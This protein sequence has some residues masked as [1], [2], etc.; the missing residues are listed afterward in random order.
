MRAG[1]YLESS[2]FRSQLQANFWNTAVLQL[3]VLDILKCLRPRK[4]L[5]NSMSKLAGKQW[6]VVMFPHTISAPVNDHFQ[7]EDVSMKVS[8]PKHFITLY[9]TMLQVITDVNF[10]LCITLLNLCKLLYF[11]QSKLSDLIQRKSQW[12]KITYK[13]VL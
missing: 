4:F 10:F 9:S 13:K 8:G 6:C 11:L 7:M 12:T 1:P 5:R 3:Q 2:G